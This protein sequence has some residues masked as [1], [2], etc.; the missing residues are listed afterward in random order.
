[1][2]PIGCS[3]VSLKGFC[4]HSTPMTS[5]TLRLDARGPRLGPSQRTRG[6]ARC[7]GCALTPG[8]CLCAELPRLE[9]RARVVVVMHHVELRKTTNT[10]RLAVRMLEG[11]ELRVRGEREASERRPLPVGKRLVL[12][13]S[14]DA[15]ELQPSLVAPGAPVVLLAPDGTW[16]Q[17]RRAL[18]RDPDLSG[19]IPV[20]LPA[21]PPSQYGLR[22]HPRE[23]G[24]S[25]LEA[26]ARALAILETPTIAE[27]M[28][29]VFDEFVRRSLAIRASGKG[30]EPPAR[31]IPGQD[32]ILR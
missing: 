21:G 25:T 3:L 13:P 27:A 5:P 26:I 11:A 18:R 1:M 24:L 29:S 32:R 4:E 19:A 20:T 10:G 22:R 31:E 16:T 30:G 7:E 12:Y 6:A 28:L 23:G 9:P 15:V 17:A 2:H 14:D 8:L